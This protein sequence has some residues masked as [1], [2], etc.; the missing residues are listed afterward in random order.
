MKFID[1]SKQYKE[2]KNKIDAAIHKVL[3]HGKYLMGPE[4]FEI[5]EKIADYI[6]VKHALSIYLLSWGCW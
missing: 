2:Q 3:D 5:E 4:V 1:L 6:G